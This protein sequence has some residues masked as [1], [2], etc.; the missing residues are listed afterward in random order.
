MFAITMNKPAVF[1]FV[2]TLCFDNRYGVV[3]RHAVR[4]GDI[5]RPRVVVVTFRCRVFVCYHFSAVA[6][7]AVVIARDLARRS[8][9]RRREIVQGR[10]RQ[11]VVSAHSVTAVASIV[12][13]LSQTV[14]RR[15]AA[16]R[17][18]GLHGGRAMPQDAAGDPRYTHET[19]VAP[20]ERLFALSHV[21]QHVRQTG[22][23]GRALHRRRLGDVRN[24]T[25]RTR[26][27]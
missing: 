8:H 4:D 16:R 24:G 25:S 15:L 14:S 19:Q 7:F 21:E 2:D 1:H 3:S 26:R 9:H 6:M 18:N 23:V 11:N 22:Q 27:K 10:R 12:R 5:R 13:R 20:S 17:L